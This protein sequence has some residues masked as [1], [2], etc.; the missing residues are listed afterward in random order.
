MQRVFSLRTVIFGTFTLASV[1]AL[2]ST[3]GPLG[4]SAEAQ[5]DRAEQVSLSGVFGVITGDPRSE[6]PPEFEYVLTDEQGRW[7]DLSIDEKLIEREGGTDALDGEQVEVVGTGVPDEEIKVRSIELEQP[8][9]VATAGKKDFLSG[10]QPTV[11][12]L[13]RFSDATSKTPQTKKYFEGAMGGTK[14]G[15]DNYWREVSYG[16]IDLKGSK[17]AGW[18][19][20]PKPRAHYVTRDT[21]GD[22]KANLEKLAKDCTTIAQKDV[23][24]PNFTNINLIFNQNLDSSAWGGRGE[25]LKLNGQTKEYGVTWIPSYVFENESDEKGLHTLAHEM[26]HSFGLDHSSGPYEETYDSNWDVMSNGSVCKPPNT[27]YGCIGVHPISYQKERLGWIPNGNRYVAGSG[28]DRSITIQRLGEFSKNGYLMAQIPIKGS[29]QFYTVEARRLLGYDDKANL[30]GQAIVI[31]KVTTPP[32]DRAAR[33]VV[34]A[35]KD[36]KKKDPNGKDAMW[37]PGE[38]F[39]DPKNGITV[40]VTKETTNGYT[41]RISKK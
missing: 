25:Q 3:F 24:F 40:Q 32:G 30:P 31:H 2:A 8:E 35:S 7:T 14:P 6:S 38:T 36:G 15:L 23:K 13:C 20:L 16:K 4:L 29:T 5:T 22:T 12:V 33:V 11:T 19:N 41:V 10:S 34:D 37:L 26:G 27:T 18:Y 17:V 39:K 28:S 9:K 21:K 1:V